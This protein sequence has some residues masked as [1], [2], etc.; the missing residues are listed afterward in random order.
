M[1]AIKLYELSAGRYKT[2]VEAQTEKDIAMIPVWLMLCL[3]NA[4]SLFGL[5]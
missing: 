1:T 2:Q 3:I 4:V 5:Y